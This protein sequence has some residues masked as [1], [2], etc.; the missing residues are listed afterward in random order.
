MSSWVLLSPPRSYRDNCPCLPVAACQG[1]AD[2]AAPTGNSPLQAGR[3]CGRCATSGHARRR[4]PPLRAGR[5]RPLLVQGALA[6]AG[7]HLSSLHL[8]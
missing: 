3:S 1:S 8:L 6:T 2:A 5:N 7:R 4:L